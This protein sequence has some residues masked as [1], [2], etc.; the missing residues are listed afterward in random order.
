M[1][2]APALDAVDKAILRQV[3]SHLPL[4]PRPYAKLAAQLGLAED[5]LLERL[6]RLKKLGVIRRIGG[7]FDST[8]LG[9]AATL[10]GAKVP[11]EKF[12]RF[13]EEVNSHPGVTHNYRREHDY[14]VW[15][16]YIAE[17]KEEI[18]EQLALIAQRTGVSQI[19]SMPA[20][21]KYKIKVDFPI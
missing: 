4:D 11:P 8:S 19:C 13:V 21:T 17:S 20:I 12:E 1:S 7:N 9:F 2:S 3:Q 6:A 15:F 5:Q 14:N 10:C 18:E 16:T